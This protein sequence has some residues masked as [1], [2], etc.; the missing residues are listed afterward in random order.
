MDIY[1]V[2]FYDFEI[3]MSKLIGPVQVLPIEYGTHSNYL[4]ADKCKQLIQIY[5]PYLCR[6]DYEYH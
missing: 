3:F 2:W 5:T 6:F 4:D 1:D